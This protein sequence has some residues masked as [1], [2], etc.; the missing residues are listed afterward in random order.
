M[1]TDKEKLEMW[2]DD[3]N[4]SEN[5]WMELSFPEI[6]K[7]ADVN[8]HNACVQLPRIIAKRTVKKVWEVREKRNTFRKRNNLPYAK[9][10]KLTK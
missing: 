2:L 10:K 5:T 4:T 9:K 1:I 7:L 8:P 6:D 3:P